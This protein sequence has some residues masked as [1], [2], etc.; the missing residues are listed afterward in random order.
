MRLK[1]VHHLN[2]MTPESMVRARECLEEAL[3]FDSRFVSAR[4]MLATYFTSSRPTV[5]GR[6]TR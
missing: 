1:G 4:C 6:L 5:I 3:A 2:V